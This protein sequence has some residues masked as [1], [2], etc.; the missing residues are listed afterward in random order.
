MEFAVIR[1]A[2]PAAV[3][4]DIPGFPDIPL[5][6]A[7]QSGVQQAE[8]SGFAYD[9]HSHM[10]TNNHV[11]A[12][13]DKIVVTFSDGTEVAA[14]L[15]GTDPDSDLAVIKV[16]RWSV[17]RPAPKEDGDAESRPTP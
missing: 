4:G 7:P 15:V 2:R 13:E 5:S 1:D 11:I 9:T 10:V 14:T 17:N 3:T 12:K 8:G 16:A 6:E